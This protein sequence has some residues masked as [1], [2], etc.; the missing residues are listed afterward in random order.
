MHS[1]NRLNISG[2]FSGNQ[3]SSAGKIP[4]LSKRDFDGSNMTSSLP[5][6][7]TLYCNA[8]AKLC[9]ALPPA[10]KVCFHFLLFYY[11]YRLNDFAATIII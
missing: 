7:D 5:L 1:K 2:Y 8:N 6:P 10:M 4:F 11:V 9:I 3:P